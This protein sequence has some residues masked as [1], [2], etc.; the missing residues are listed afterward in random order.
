M[1]TDID[2]GPLWRRRT[3]WW[4]RGASRMSFVD[5]TVCGEE[6]RFSRAR[7]S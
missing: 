6:K 3:R 1:K 5:P 2:S 4:G 7:A